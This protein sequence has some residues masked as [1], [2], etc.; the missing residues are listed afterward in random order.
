MQLYRKSG[1]EIEGRLRGYM[2]RQGVL[3]DAYLMRRLSA[4]LPHITE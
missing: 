4:P 2:L 1:F 3:V